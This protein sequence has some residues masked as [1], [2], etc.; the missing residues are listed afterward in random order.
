MN[1]QLSQ[2]SS[3]AFLRTQL[4]MQIINLVDFY[5]T[6]LADFY[7]RWPVGRRNLT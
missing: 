3:R 5:I 7:E 4:I 1:E 2:P 6:G